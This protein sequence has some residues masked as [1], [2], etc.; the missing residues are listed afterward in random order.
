MADLP[1]PPSPDAGSSSGPGAGS[2]SS[3]GPHELPPPYRLRVGSPLDRALL[4]QA[5][6]RTYEELYPG[7]TFDH[8]GATL[9]AYLGPDTPLWWLE[10][11]TA[12]S[13][14]PPRLGPMPRPSPSGVLWMGTAVDQVSGARH[15]HIFLLYVAPGHRRLGLGRFLMNQAEDWAKARGDRHISLQVFAHNQPALQ[16]YNNLGYRTQS[17]ALIKNL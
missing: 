3:S 14:G 13:P 1:S 7:Q 11:Q 8:L 9:E 15:A 6:Q 4:L 12:A 17:I 16:L 2:S 5:M 10:S